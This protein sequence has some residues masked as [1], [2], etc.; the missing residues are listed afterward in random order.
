MP[1]PRWSWASDATPGSRVSALETEAKADQPPIELPAP[2]APV[3]FAQHIKPLFRE[4]DRQSMKFAFDLWSYDDVRANAQAILQYV[5]AGTMPCD[6]AWPEEWV[7]AL[8][9]WTAGGMNP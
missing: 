4:R 8:E 5:S 1:V 6:G 2:G 3:G 7:A 9:R